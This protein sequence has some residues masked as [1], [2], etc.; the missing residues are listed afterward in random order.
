MNNFSAFLKKVGKIL[1]NKYVFTVV[2][3]FVF[4]IFFDQNNL[5]ERW[6][7]R[8]N[9]KNMEKEIAYYQTDID[10]NKQ[11]MREMRSS[12]ESLEKYAREQYY[13]KKD[14]EDI[15]IIEE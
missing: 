1:L 7:T 4:L 3:F 14:S 11:K 12:S 15:F 8:R 13:F 2:I 9:I 6:N 5:I 10:N